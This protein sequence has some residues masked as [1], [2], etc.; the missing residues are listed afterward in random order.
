MSASMVSPATPEASGHWEAVGGLKEIM[1]GLRIDG[2]PVAFGPTAP[3]ES[4]DQQE[5]PCL[6]RRLYH[7]VRHLDDR[8]ETACCFGRAAS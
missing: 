8:L 5:A 3:E 2:D 7:R 6:C 4:V 1:R